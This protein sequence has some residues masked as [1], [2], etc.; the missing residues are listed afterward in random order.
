MVGDRDLVVNYVASIERC[1]HLSDVRVAETT[2][3]VTI[4]IV[5]ARFP[6]APETCTLVGIDA[7]VR[8]SLR[9]PLD[10]RTL[11]DGALPTPGQR[12]LRSSL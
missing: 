10:G 3:S 5:E 2:T 9:A 1:R 7:H 8:V 4:T 11:L 6:G 12:P